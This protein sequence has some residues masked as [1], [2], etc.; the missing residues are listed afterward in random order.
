MDKKHRDWLPGDASIIELLIS[1]RHGQIRKFLLALVL[2]WGTC[3]TCRNDS[4]INVERDD[5]GFGG[6]ELLLSFN[7]VLVLAR[8]MQHKH[9]VERTEP[10]DGIPSASVTRSCVTT[11]WPRRL[12]AAGETETKSTDSF[13]PSFHIIGLF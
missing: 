12:Q 4:G 6:F 1:S 8:P 11:G 3:L 10:G 2:R 9:L 13:L 5:G 7:G